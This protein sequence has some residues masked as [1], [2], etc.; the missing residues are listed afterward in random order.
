M[1]CFYE[2]CAIVG[3]Q[4]ILLISLMVFLMEIIVKGYIAGIVKTTVQFNGQSAFPD[5]P[6]P[7][8]YVISRFTEF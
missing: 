4:F 8:K 1:L 2:P 3:V 5:S 6:S 7:Q